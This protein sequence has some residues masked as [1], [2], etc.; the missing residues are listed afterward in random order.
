MTSWRRLLLGIGL[1]PFVTGCLQNVASAPEQPEV[2]KNTAVTSAVPATSNAPVAEVPSA[3]VFPEETPATTNAPAENAAPANQPTEQADG[4]VT[5]PATP[6]AER[7]L[8]PN[9]RANSA[10]TELLRMV[11]SGVDEGVLLAYVTNS[12]HTFNLGADEI[13]YLNDLGVPGSVVTAMIQR[14]NALKE[15]S[16][17]S[18]ASTLA[19]NPPPGTYAPAP[20]VEPASPA[21]TA[22]YAAPETAPT[23]GTFEQALSPYGSWINVDGYGV[24]WQP[25]VVVVNPGW[26][27]YY[28][29]GRWVYT[30]CGW[31]WYSDYS[32]GWAPFHYGRWFQHSHYGWCWYPGYT[33]GPSWVTW[34]YYG[35][36]CG[37]AALPP[38]A[39][40]SPG[41]G[42]TYYGSSVGFGF[43][44]GLS[45]SC[46]SFVHWNDLHGHPYHHGHRVPHHEVDKFF[47]KTTAVTRIAGNNN[48]VVN[49]GIS[50]ELVKNATSTP[51]RTVSLKPTSG[52]DAMRL[53][54]ERFSADGQTL[55]VNRPSV[56]R[57]VSTPMSRPA[58]TELAETTA[59]AVRVPA[60][61]TRRERIEVP[62][63]RESSP[64]TRS[65]SSSTT[66]SQKS[67]GTTGQSAVERSASPEGRVRS[68]VVSSRTIPL[69]RLPGTPRTQVNRPETAPTQAPPR[70]E[71]SRQAP[72]VR[73]P[74]IQWRGP[75]TADGDVDSRANIQQQ[76]QRVLRQGQVVSRAPA[77]APRNVEV[78]RYAP[79]PVQIPS[80]QPPQYIPPVTSPQTPRYSAP[81]QAPRYTAPT[82]SS[83]Y[84]AP[85][86]SPPR[87]QAPITP[88]YSRP[89]P[90]A[91]APS[92]APAVTPRSAP[93]PAPV[94]RVDAGGGSR[95]SAGRFDRTR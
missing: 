25:T 23:Q 66:G 54:R 80:Q 55:V 32:W 26:S 12:I 31:Y 77:Q 35:D 78:P 7:T 61:M 19:P 92:P 79:E 62:D 49:K 37:W 69:D 38:Y 76:P 8:P 71:S 15:A 72:P 40:W 86:Y 22:T 94:P 46:Y 68:P 41:F 87:V 67:T 58:R 14:D 75:Q 82:A 57:P 93:A 90:S 39:V 70:T 11:D 63:S 85:S 3:P 95:G 56:I 64:V 51:V 65:E 18:V 13:I 20:E 91:P 27:P 5:A 52:P 16:E 2:Y 74:A 59:T 21:D 53:R 28:D 45:S 30:D 4:A 50:P 10:V 60:T 29:S 44:F 48:T 83:Q 81:V 89:A 34:R 36:Y 47:N 42:F 43:S 9:I 17:P 73:Q 33:W 1:V 24:V 6:V 88:S 84:Q